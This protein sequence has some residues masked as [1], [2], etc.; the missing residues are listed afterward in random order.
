[1]FLTHLEDKTGKHC[2]L[3]SQKQNKSCQVMCY[4]SNL[5]E[6]QKISYELPVTSYAGENNSDLSLMFGLT[7]ELKIA[8]SVF[9]FLD[10]QESWADQINQQRKQRN[11]T[12]IR[13][14]FTI[15]SLTLQHSTTYNK[16]VYLKIKYTGT[17]FKNNWLAKGLV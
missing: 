10:M 16:N 6:K 2:R 14:I 1:M 11:R 7:E 5:S 13:V 9:I 3:S 15:N 17:F 8:Y 4:Q 12:K